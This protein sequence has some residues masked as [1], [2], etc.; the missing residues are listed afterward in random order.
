MCDK[1]LDSVAAVTI[2]RTDS[3]VKS[4]LNQRAQQRRLKSNNTSAPASL[5]GGSASGSASSS[6]QWTG[7][8]MM[9]ESKLQELQRLFSGMMIQ[10]GLPFS[11]ADHPAVKEL[12]AALNS[13]FKVPSSYQIANKYLLAI[14]GLNS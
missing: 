14:Y 1:F 2:S 5:L 3:D 8:A 13:A 9:S 4:A 6:A 7:Y 12:F 11:W 10:T